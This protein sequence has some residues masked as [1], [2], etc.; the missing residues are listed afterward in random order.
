MRNTFTILSKE[1]QG[2]FASPLAYGMLALFGLLSGYFFSVYVYMFIDRSSLPRQMGGG[3]PMNVNDWVLVP[4]ISNLG[5]LALFLIPMLAMRLFAEE[6]RSGTIEL[7]VTS[8]IRD[9]EIVLGKWLAAVLLLACMLVLSMFQA[10]LLF[11]YGA[12]DIS[13]VLTGYLGLLLL[14]GALLAIGIF[15]SSTTRSQVLAGIATFAASLLLWVLDW[16]GQIDPSANWSK[17]L[18]YLSVIAHFE[19]FTKG[20]I[21]S[22]DVVFYLSLIVLGLFLTTRSIESLRW[23][24]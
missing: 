24:A 10:A 1:L 17:V 13:P 18:G 2:Y 9:V 21:D 15:I 7:L 6:K 20:I 19:P 16:A 3:G 14:G 11:A 22:K 5:V 23:R 4:M 8:P 12:P